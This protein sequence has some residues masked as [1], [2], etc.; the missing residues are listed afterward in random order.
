MTLE[1]RAEKIALHLNL[2][3]K[4]PWV[5][6][7]LPSVAA[8]IR[9]AVEEAVTIER[10][11]CDFLH[12]NMKAEAYEDAAKIAENAWRVGMAIPPKLPDASEWVA[13]LIRARAKESK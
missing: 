2:D 1:E 9:A 10:D 8:E 12:K 4:A 7:Y 13:G 3:P 6:K 5:S 11:K